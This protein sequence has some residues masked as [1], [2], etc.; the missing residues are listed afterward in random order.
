MRLES[1]TVIRYS[2]RSRR[3]AWFRLTYEVRGGPGPGTEQW[4]LVGMEELSDLSQAA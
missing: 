3:E 4:F 1:A 2:L